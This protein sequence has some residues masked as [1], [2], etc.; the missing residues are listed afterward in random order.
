MIF[1]FGGG[2]SEGERVREGRD[3]WRDR[4]ILIILLLYLILG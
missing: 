3:T 1:W 2:G 4:W